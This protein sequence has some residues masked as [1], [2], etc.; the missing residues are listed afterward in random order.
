MY[1]DTHHVRV[2]GEIRCDIS[3]GQ[4][5][6]DDRQLTTKRLLSIDA[7]FDYSTSAFNRILRS[8]ESTR[9]VRALH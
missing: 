7:A 2:D 1:E 4:Q 8:R 9:R 5:K 6:N 3:G